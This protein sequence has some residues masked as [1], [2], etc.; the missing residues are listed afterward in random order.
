MEKACM[1]DSLVEIRKFLSDQ[2][3]TVFLG[4]DETAIRSGIKPQF[5]NLV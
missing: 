2:F 1:E 3:K 4:E 5:V